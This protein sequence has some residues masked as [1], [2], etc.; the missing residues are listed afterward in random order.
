MRKYYI[1]SNDNKNEFPIFFR[2]FIFFR[3]FCKAE[4]L[5]L[6]QDENRS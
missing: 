3:T 5:T 4:T 1:N 6:G 2:Y